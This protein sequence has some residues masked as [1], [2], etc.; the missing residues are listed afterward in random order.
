M[1]ICGAPG[2]YTWLRRF[3]I[4]ISTNRRSMDKYARALLAGA[5]AGGLTIF[6][7]SGMRL[8]AI[9]AILAIVILITSPKPVEKVQQDNE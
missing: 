3:L 9:V 5:L 6:V 1:K 4:P 7:L 2:F 8:F